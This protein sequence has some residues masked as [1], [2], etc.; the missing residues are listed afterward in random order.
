MLKTVETFPYEIKFGKKIVKYRGWKTRDEKAYLILTE[1]KE[2]IDDKDLFDTLVIPCIENKKMFFSIAEKQKL[3]IEI[4]KKSLGE[5]FDIKYICKND[6]CKTVND[7][8]VNFDEIVEFKDDTVSNIK[9]DNIEFFF[10]DIKNP[11]LLEKMND[12][13]TNVEK[14][15]NEMVMRIEKLI[16]DSTVEDTFTFEEISNYI[17]DLD[18]HIFDKLVEYYTSNLSSIEMKGTLTCH[19]CGHQNEFIFDEI[20]NFLAGW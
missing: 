2:E 18:T 4:R 9:I 14:V 10:G 17:D 15:F 3:I 19:R 6:A 1:S 20:P 7:V 16:I 8:Q 13:K 5:S 12:N 11:T